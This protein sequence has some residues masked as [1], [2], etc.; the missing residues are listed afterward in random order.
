MM[1]CWRFLWPPAASH[2]VGVSVCRCRSFGRLYC[3]SP[4]FLFDDDND[5]DSSARRR[6]NEGV[7]VPLIKLAVFGARRRYWLRVFAVR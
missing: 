4:L 6:R 2:R 1:F 5:D 7:W 3:A